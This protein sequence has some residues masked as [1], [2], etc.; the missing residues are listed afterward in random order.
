MDEELTQ[1]QLNHLEMVAEMRAID[2]IKALD[3]YCE[4]YIKKKPKYLPRFIYQFILNKLVVLGKY[5][6]L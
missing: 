3:R 1:G 4:L 2:G 6:P 5:E